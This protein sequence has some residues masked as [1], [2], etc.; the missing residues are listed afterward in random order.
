MEKILVGVF[1]LGFLLVMAGVT[2]AFAESQKR[3]SCENLAYL[4]P[5]DEFNGITSQKSLALRFPVL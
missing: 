2:L 1:V 4:L 3:A 5:V